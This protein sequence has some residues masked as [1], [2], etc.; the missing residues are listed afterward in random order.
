MQNN[1]LRQAQV[2]LDI[3]LARYFELYDLAPV[4]YCSVSEKGLISQANLTTVTL[5]GMTATS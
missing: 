4:G 5:L 3:S 1:K 2:A